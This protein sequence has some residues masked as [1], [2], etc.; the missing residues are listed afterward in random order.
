MI[1]LENIVREYKEKG[2]VDKLKELGRKTRKLFT[3]HK[4]PHLK[5]NVDRIYISRKDGGRG[6]MSCESTIRSEENNLG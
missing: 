5:S 4:G 1:L 3:V 2:G 6:M